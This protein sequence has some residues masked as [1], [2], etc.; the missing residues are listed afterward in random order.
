LW[1]PSGP[2]F[3]LTGRRDLM[4]DVA[5]SGTDENLFDPKPTSQHLSNFWIT[6]ANQTGQV[7][8]AENAQNAS[9]VTVARTFAQSGQSAGGR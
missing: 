8:V 4:P 9:N 3:L 5:T 7:S 1:A 2:I 6:V